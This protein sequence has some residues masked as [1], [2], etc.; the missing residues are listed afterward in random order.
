MKALFK[1]DLFAGRLM[2][3]GRVVDSSKENGG[4]IIEDTTKFK[5]SCDLKIA[6]CEASTEQSRR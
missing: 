5:K 2:P 1:F 3:L 6:S 4:F